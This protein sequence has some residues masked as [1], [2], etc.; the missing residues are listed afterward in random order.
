M[1]RSHSQLAHY[2]VPAAFLLAVTIVVLIIHSGLATNSSTSSTTPTRSTPLTQTAA[3]KHHR[4]PRTRYY[5]VQ[6]GEGFYVI[7]QKFHTTVSNIERLNK[8]VSSN[9]LRI[10]Q[11]LVV[12]G[13][14]ARSK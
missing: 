14:P 5:T 2:G 4:P 1:P 11:Q 9:S 10:G 8:G 13:R 3:N 12:G 6:A 7:A